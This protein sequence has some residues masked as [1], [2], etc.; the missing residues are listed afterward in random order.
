MSPSPAWAASRISSSASPRWRTISTNY[1]RPRTSTRTCT[2]FTGANSTKA[3]LTDTLAQIA[4]DAKPDDDF[5]LILIGHGS[6]DG[7]EYKFN[8]PGPGYFRRRAG[9]ALRPHCRQATVDREYHQRERRLGRRAAT[10]RTRR[11][12]GDQ[13]RHRKKRHGLRA[14]L[15]RGAAGCLGGRRQ[16][17]V[18]QR[19]GGV[20]IRR[21]QNRGFLRFAKAPGH[22]ARRFRRHGQERSGARSLGGNGEGLLAASFTLLRIGAAQKAANDPAKRALLDKKEELEQKIDT[23]KYQKAAMSADDYKKQLTEAL[24]ELAKVQEDLDK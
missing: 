6:Y 9:R 18:H 3:H 16:E 20:S 19:P 12:H 15:G 22:R 8:L 21:P 2:T 7:D 17:R 10:G 4:R 13:I 23:L 24:V 1:S 5:T 14:L 11:D